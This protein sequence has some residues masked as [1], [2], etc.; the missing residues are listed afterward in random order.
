MRM[1]TRIAGLLAITAVIAA[2]GG[3]I[4]DAEAGDT[5]GSGTTS[6]E[7][8][9]EEGTAVASLADVRDAV[10]RIEGQG[11]FADPM[12][13]E[14][15]NVPGSGSGFLIDGSG[16]ALT[17]NH[18]VTG[19][20][21]LDVFVEGEDGPRSARVVAVSECLDL[22]LIDV[23]GE[24]GSW[25]TFYDGTSEPGTDVF[26][27]GFPLGDPEYSLTEGVVSR[28]PRPGVTQFASVQNEI[29]HTAATLPGNS[30]GPLVSTDGQVVGVVY[31]VRPDTSQFFAIGAADV[32]ASLEALRAGEDVEALGLNGEAFVSDELSGIFV[33]SVETGSP[34]HRAGIRAGDLVTRLEG[35][36][37]AA[38]GTMDT[39][40]RILRSHRAGDPLS[41]QVLRPETGQLLEGTLNV[42]DGEL[43]ERE[44]AMTDGRAE[45]MAETTRVQNEAG[46]LSV[47]VPSGWSETES[48]RWT[49][50][51]E[52]MGQFLAAA[53]DVEEFLAGASPGMLIGIS[54]S[55]A[56]DHDP[57]SLLATLGSPG[58]GCADRQVDDYDDG[59][60]TGTYDSWVGCAGSSTVYRI[61]TRTL[62]GDSLVLVQVRV[63][64]ASNGA[65]A[66][67]IAST[68]VAVD[69]A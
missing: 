8:V 7:S 28:S 58:A 65:E 60:Y 26:A 43:A 59:V 68:F 42:E 20:A 69:P 62:S 38:D 34:A 6:P 21:F 22:A 1:G 14:L 48:G 57:A 44:A 27:A 50:E 32:N 12:G 2:C 4:I 37:L 18:V 46:T 63:P 55:L 9:T 54:T 52:D 23:D 13:G 66:D 10:V 30:G 49:L 51:G 39:Y 3:P 61:A 31:A 11:T 24:F 35:I 15:A 45:A 25:L 36:D 17:A 29:E 40:C 41:V 19:S 67:L 64:R 16:L 5:G 33:Y 56:D 47:D 53:P